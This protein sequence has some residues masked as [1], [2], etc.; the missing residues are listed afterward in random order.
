[1]LLGTQRARRHVWGHHHAQCEI[2]QRDNTARKA[3]TRHFIRGANVRT[4][5]AP[6]QVLTLRNLDFAHPTSATP[7]AHWNVVAIESLHAVEHALVGLARKTFGRIGHQHFKTRD[8]RHRRRNNGLRANASLA[9]A[10]LRNF[11]V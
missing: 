8:Y 11:S 1:M 2:G 10:A 7:A 3:N 5:H 4:A 6:A 9:S